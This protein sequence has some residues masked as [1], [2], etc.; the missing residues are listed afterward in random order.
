M[1]SKILIVDDEESNGALLEL[2]LSSAGFE[3][4]VAGTGQKALS[5]VDNT[6]NIAFV[7]MH[8]PDISGTDVVAR[9]RQAVP[10]LFIAI[11]TMD[12][13]ASTIRAAYAAGAD[14]FLAKPY[15][16]AT[17]AELV[18]GAKRGRRWLVD[19]L[20]IREYRGAPNSLL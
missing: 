16:V 20:G 10:E 8:L 19:R 14:M 6:F 18:R 13:S 15:E 9:L 17:L 12:D 1:T 11:A 4:V 7:D 2:V 3:V 5:L